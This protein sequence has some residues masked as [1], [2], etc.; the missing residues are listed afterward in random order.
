MLCSSLRLRPSS[1]AERLLVPTNFLSQLGEYPTL[2]SLAIDNSDSSGSLDCRILLAYLFGLGTR[3]I[4]GAGAWQC[5]IGI[6]FIFAAILGVG[7]QFMPESPVRLASGFSFV[8][9]LS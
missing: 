5:L 4:S 1:Y 7:I 9:G 6:G 8:T 3:E 2:L